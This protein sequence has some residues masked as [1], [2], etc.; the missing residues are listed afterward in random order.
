MGN[1]YFKRLCL[2]RIKLRNNFKNKLFLKNIIILFSFVT[3]GA[4]EVNENIKS[5]SNEMFNKANNFFYNLKIQKMKK[6]KKLKVNL[7]K[8]I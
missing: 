8:I 4:C 1:I 3:L 7:L 2:I 6:I 5:V